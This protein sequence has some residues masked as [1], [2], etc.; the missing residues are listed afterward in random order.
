MP[1]SKTKHA[2]SPFKILWNCRTKK[3]CYIHSVTSNFHWNRFSHIHIKSQP[4]WY[5]SGKSFALGCMYNRFIK[6]ELLVENWWKIVEN[7]FKV[8]FKLRCDWCSVEWNCNIA[9]EWINWQNWINDISERNHFLG[10]S[11]FTRTLLCIISILKQYL[12]LNDGSDYVNIFHSTDK[13]NV[14]SP[15]RSW[16]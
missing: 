6:A 13:S 12:A 8:C 9:F 16:F 4:S 7:K 14:S 3:K 1:K 15:F 2:N 10:E 11:F 5:M